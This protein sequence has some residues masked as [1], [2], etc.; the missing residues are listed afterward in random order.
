MKVLQLYPA[1]GRE[2]LLPSSLRADFLSGDKDFSLTRTGGPYTSGR[3]F[4]TSPDLK[5]FDI[6]VLFGSCDV[7][8]RSSDP[9]PVVMIDRK[10]FK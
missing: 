2:Y 7:S 5:D 9:T 3:E 10:D 4:Q 6:A 8:I 1:Y